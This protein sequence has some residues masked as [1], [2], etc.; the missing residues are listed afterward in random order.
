MRFTDGDLE[1]PDNLISSLSKDKLVIFVGAGVSAR[2]YPNQSP[3]S[4]FPTFRE[5]VHQIAE[6]LEKNLSAEEKI[7]IKLGFFDRVLGEW[8]GE[9]EA[10][11]GISVHNIAA[12]IL[13]SDSNKKRTIL[14]RAIIQLF[15]EG[16]PPRIVTTN[17]DTLLIQARD[18]EGKENDPRWKIYYAPALPPAKRFSGICFLHGRVSDPQDMVLTDKGIGRAYMEEGWALK[19]AHEMFR[20]FDVLFVG[21]S[22]QDPPLRYLSLALEGAIDKKRWAFVP[23]PSQSQEKKKLNDDWIRRGVKPIWFP[24]LRKNYRTLETTIAAW[25]DDNRRGYVDR[26][27]ILSDWARSS[28]SNLLPHN[29]D[30][31]K[32]YLQT[33][34]LL[35]DFANSDFDEAWFDKLLE[36]GHLDFLLKGSG[37]YKQADWELASALNKRL[38]EDSE[39][40]ISKLHSF[41]K[42]LQPFFFEQFCREFDKNENNQFDCN[43]LRKLLEFFSFT[44]NSKSSVEYALSIGRILKLL[45]EKNHVD[46]AIWLFMSI[47]H[48]EIK[49]TMKPSFSYFT[50]QLAGENVSDLERET[51]E[52]DASF[53]SSHPQAYVIEQ[54]IQTIFIP[55]IE[56]AGFPLLK[57]LTRKL[58]ELRTALGRVG[59][60]E[61]TYMFRATIEPNENNLH[62][63]DDPENIFIDS[64]RDLWK[65]LLE[66]NLKKAKE[67]YKIWNE[68]D[69]LIFRRLSI[70]AITKILEREYVQ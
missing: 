7:N 61:R 17:F 57:E 28:S 23:T 66:I 13:S 1:I 2:V 59:I 38:I 34:E 45:I 55:N 9:I 22:L 41:R 39:K 68:I 35:R 29:L 32:Y 69:D 18:S 43:K 65:K 56:K 25:A 27:N 37:Q 67:I 64:L 46:D 40:W 26:K 3:A 11:G 4:Y 44:I 52:C 42:T 24:A 20:E 6:K 15:P 51:L 12:E 70:H 30:Q 33:P 54:L 36:W 5:L 31:V 19:F 62:S 50:A 47:V 21:Y 60:E 49:F 63:D 8:Q 53:V 10:I 48:F 58:C 16:A 14:H